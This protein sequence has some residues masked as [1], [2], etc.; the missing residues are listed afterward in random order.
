LHSR[1]QQVEPRGVEA[2]GIALGTLDGDPGG[3]PEAHIFAKDRAPWDEISDSLPRF[4]GDVPAEA[5]V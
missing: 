1:K 4:D 5:D 3:R 2:I